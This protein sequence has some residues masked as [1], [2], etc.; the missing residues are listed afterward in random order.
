MLGEKTFVLVFFL[1]A[2]LH[3]AM[4]ITVEEQLSPDKSRQ[5]PG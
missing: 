3:I 2:V 4:G 5:I 1:I